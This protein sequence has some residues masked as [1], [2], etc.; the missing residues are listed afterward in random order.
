MGHSD[1]ATLPFFKS[2]LTPLL[3]SI[4][5]ARAA[6]ILMLINNNKGL[7]A[8]KIWEDPQGLLIEHSVSQDPCGCRQRR[9]GLCWGGQSSTTYRQSW[10][11]VCQKGGGVGMYL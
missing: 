9:A 1:T 2:M 6:Q 3:D 5:T 4:K 7:P 10:P 11:R 8:E